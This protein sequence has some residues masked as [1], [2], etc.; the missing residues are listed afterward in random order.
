MPPTSGN[1]IL[2][3]TPD[4]RDTFML[5]ASNRLAS[6]RFSQS[7]NDRKSRA[8]QFVKICGATD[9][10]RRPVG[11]V[12]GHRGGRLRSIAP[13]QMPFNRSPNLLRRPCVSVGF[14][15]A[16]LFVH[17]AAQLALHCF[18][19]VVDD[20]FQ[21]FVRA[22]VHLPFVGD[23]LVPWRHRHIDTAPVWISFLMRVIGL[24]DGHI[25]A[26]DV[27]AKSLKSRCIFQNEVVD[28]VR[29]FQTPI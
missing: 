4:L 2:T 13:T 6:K 10:K 25:A 28:L 7:T 3:I 15:V 8:S 1:L 18:E 19:R 12:A 27:V 9:G 23:E 16:A 20:F 17:D 11:C 29:F 26:V 21:R 22:V 14:D 24:F 5:L